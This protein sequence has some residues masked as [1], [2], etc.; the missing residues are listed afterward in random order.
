[1][2]RRSTTILLIGLLTLVLGGATTFAAL[3]GNKKASADTGKAQ[4][5][6]TAPTGQPTTF[7]IPDGKQALAISLDPVA[8]TAGTATVGSH[9]DV[10]AAVSQ[11]MP[12]GKGN[13]VDVHA[14]RL[15][16]QDVEVLSMPGAAVLPA[17]GKAVAAAQPSSNGTTFI[18]SVTPA[19]AEKLVFHTSFS[20][21]YFS[22]LPA[23]AKPVAP[24]AGVTTANQ[25]DPVAAG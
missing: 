11:K 8:G 9:I 13:E 6:A 14:A 24:T 15:V 7:T 2:Q 23:N 20:K 5:Q 21:L 25:L 22:V 4:V 19:E 3:R 16:L 12:D 18:L 17:A 10:Y 1:M